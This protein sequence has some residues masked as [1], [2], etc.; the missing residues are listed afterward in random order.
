MVTQVIVGLGVDV[1]SVERMRTAIDRQEGG[2]EQRILSPREIA[3]IA[4]RKNYAEAVAGRFAAKEAFS[5]CLDGARGVP[6]H[7]VEVISLPSGRP[8]LELTGEGL[9]RAQASGASTWHLSISHDGGVAMA[10]VILEGA[11]MP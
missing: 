11:A 10:T 2:F 8:T 6:W 1:C 4:G 7:D 9:R 5:K 3:Q